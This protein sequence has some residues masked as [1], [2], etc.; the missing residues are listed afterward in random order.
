MGLT[1]FKKVS[2]EWAAHLNQNCKT[3]GVPENITGDYLRNL[4]FGVNYFLKNDN[5][6]VNQ[7]SKNGCMKHFI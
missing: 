4:G 3:L 7:E 6:Y 2:S 1:T 5:K